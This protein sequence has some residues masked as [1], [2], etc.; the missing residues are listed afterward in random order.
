MET[1]RTQ[2]I[3]TSAA[4]ASISLRAALE[5]LRATPAAVQVLEPAELR[6]WGE[7]GRRLAMSDNESAA[8]FFAAGVE[9]LRDVPEELLP[10]IFAL[11]TRQM[12]L[13][14]SV[15]RET[16]Q[17]LPAIVKEI[18]DINTSRA[19]LDIANEVA[20][21]SAKHSTEFINASVDV[22]RALRG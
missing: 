4:L 8:S 7:M 3:E 10:A 5:F 18:A 2:I 22:S 13:S 1:Y 21:R 17:T 9:P 16:F 12:V 6:A 15:A 11:C 19:I 14:T 20:R